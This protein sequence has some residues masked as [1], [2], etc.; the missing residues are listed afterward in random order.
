MSENTINHLAIIMDG[1]RRWAKE[2]G[3]PS[4]EGHRVGYETL[5]KIAQACL[6]R[7]IKYLT[8][9]AF[10]TENWQRSTEEVSYL[11]NLLKE[12][13]VNDLVVFAKNNIRLRVFGDR[14]KLAADIQLAI[15]QAEE[16]TKNNL[17]ATLGLC[18]NYG[19]RDEI[20]RAVKKIVAQKKA[21]TEITE[22]LLAENLDTISMPDP[23]VIIRTSGEQRTSGF[24][25]W[26]AV[27]AELFFVNKHWPDFNESDLNQVITEYQNRQRRFGK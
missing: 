8:V 9:Y 25:T 13:L 21:A 10:S 16:A 18:L 23:E 14:Q 4:L 24:L 20:L 11:M 26:Q 2:H 17:G 15:S 7:G 5:K 3:L 27:Y 22:Q 19:G 12:A 1:N 6:A